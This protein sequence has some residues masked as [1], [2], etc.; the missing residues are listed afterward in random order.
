MAA[1]A[2]VPLVSGVTLKEM[3]T[4]LIK[5]LPVS[6]N[7]RYNKIVV[8]YLDNQ[9]LL[10]VNKLANCPRLYNY[11]Y[12]KFHGSF[13]HLIVITVGFFM[14]IARDSLNEVVYNF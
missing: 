9:L 5:S 14:R 12:N 10:R 2:L 3:L 1:R 7:E 11:E 4:S 6:P 8:F 13:C